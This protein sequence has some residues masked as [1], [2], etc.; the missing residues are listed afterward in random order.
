MEKSPGKSSGR[1]IGARGGCGSLEK[2]PSGDG[3]FCKPSAPCGPS[4]YSGGPK[5]NGGTDKISAQAL[6]AGYVQLLVAALAKMRSMMRMLAT[7]SAIGVGTGVS[8]RIARAKASA[9]SVY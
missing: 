8:S 5:C 6:Q 7:A 1:V 4:G 3:S 2:C 9:W